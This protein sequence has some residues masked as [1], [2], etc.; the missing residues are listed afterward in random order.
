[1]DDSRVVRCRQ[2]V[3]H[4]RQC[5]CRSFETKG[6]LAA[7]LR[8]SLR[9]GPLRGLTVL[10]LVLATLTEAALRLPASAI[11]R[12][13]ELTAVYVAARDGFLLRAVRLGATTPFQLR[14]VHLGGFH[15]EPVRISRSP[16]STGPFQVTAPLW[17]RRDHRKVIVVDADNTLW[18]GVIG[19]DGLGGIKLGSTFAP[20]VKLPNERN[21][22]LLV[23]RTFD[24]LS[25]GLVVGASTAASRGRSS[26][27]LRGR[28]GASSPVKR[29]TR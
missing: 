18:G 26:P 27:R 20:K 8:G 2:A 3:R 19:D 21:G 15:R 16:A 12:R 10:L 25:Y 22:T 6:D 14:P 13:G 28:T 17:I 1:M 7:R 4:L 9:I 29:G 11:L 24:R 23:F 5:H